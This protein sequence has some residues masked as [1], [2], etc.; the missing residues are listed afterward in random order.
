MN[1]ISTVYNIFQQALNDFNDAIQLKDTNA[2]TFFNRGNLLAMM[3]RYE[4]AEVDYSTGKCSL[5][6]VRK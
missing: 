3:K 4:E 2:H 1:D 5:R 6:Y